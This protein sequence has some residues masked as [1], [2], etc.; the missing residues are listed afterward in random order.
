MKK[1]LT[2]SFTY[3]VL[4]LLLC[5]G[6]VCFK[7]FDLQI[8]NGSEYSEQLTSRAQA[9]ITLEGRRGNI[10]D[11][12]GELLAGSRLC[13]K[14]QMVYV[15]K[16]Q[17]E[18]D[19]M[20][21]DI[22][23]MLQS[24]GDSFNNRL[25]QYITPAFQWGSN[26]AGESNRTKRSTWIKTIVENKEDADEI[27]T[28]R[29]AFDYL[30]N[31]LFKI[32]EK[33]TDEEA[34]I[35]I[36]IR[37]ATRMEGLSTLAPMTIA[38]DI[39]EESMQNVEMNYMKYPGVYTDI[40]YKRVYYYG[41]YTSH[42]IGYVRTI[43]ADEYEEL[44]GKGYLPTDLVGKMGIE[45][46]CESVLRGTDGYKT[47]YYD[48]DADVIRTL[49]RVEPVA[50]TDVYLTIDIKLQIKAY[51]AIQA[52]IAKMRSYYDPEDTNF[53]DANAGCILMED[54]NNGQ[55]LAMANYPSYDN[56]LFLAPSSDKEAQ[57]KI[58]ELYKDEDSPSL[59]RAT[60][61][62]YAI[63]STFKPL[64]AIA[65]LESGKVKDKTH[66]ENCSKVFYID[67]MPHQCTGYHHNLSMDMA[68][69]V[70]CN[71]Y[72]EKIGLLAGV[73]NIDRYAK[74][75]GLGEKTGIEIS[76]HVGNRSNEA[77][78]KLKELD[79]THKWSRSDTAQTAIGQLYTQ[80]T[81]IQLVNYTSAL[82]NGGYKNTPTLIYK[83][84]AADGTVTEHKSTRVKLDISGTTLET[85]RQGMKSVVT[86][87]GTA[88][89][90]AFSRFRYGFVAAKTGS[91]Q[92]GQEVLGKSSNACSICYAP[93]DNP[94][95]ASITFIE[96]GAWGRFTL[97]A[98]A[99]MLDTYFNK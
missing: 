74:M 99:E 44:K 45:K 92:T 60:Q 66:V 35:I 72:F 65:A 94:E 55:M 19:R 75:F 98:N 63:G 54:V 85:V 4:L 11:R 32:D 82:G 42:I 2:N 76:E 31:K 56:N 8:V 47:V 34:Y 10:Y 21:L 53:G 51:E 80:F 46:T 7:L 62:I 73:D 18:R 67:G 37:Y 36:S 69:T 57:R 3:V 58:N 33:Y 50:G 87:G 68:F 84:I 9:K 88:A 70:S 6:A 17:E 97:S 93:A 81:P 25:E 48:S 77:S 78:M 29:D 83:T 5:M 41:V 61:G 14:L 86:T 40:G 89:S 43:D 13:Y 64:V 59:N 39:S 49:N 15:N 71:T 79:D 52:T 12:N 16:P 24:N 20:Y 96:H 1:I 23:R 95:V 91:P 30:R 90:D 26:L 22:I 38:D 27:L 28:C